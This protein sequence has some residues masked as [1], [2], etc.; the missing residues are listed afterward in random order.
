MYELV[1]DTFIVRDGRIAIQSFAAKLMPKN[2]LD[3]RTP[4]TTA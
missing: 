2:I 1:T 3:R 4:L